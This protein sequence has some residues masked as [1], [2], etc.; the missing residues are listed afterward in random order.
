MLTLSEYYEMGFVFSAVAA[1]LI[2]IE[3]SLGC[4]Y[5]TN[6]MSSVRQRRLFGCQLVAGWLL[7]V[8]NRLGENEPITSLRARTDAAPV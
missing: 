4:H 1:M 8:S 2:A 7:I 5:A 6:R 3:G